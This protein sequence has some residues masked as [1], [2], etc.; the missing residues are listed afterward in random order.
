MGRHRVCT[1]MRLNG[2]RSVWRRQFVHTS[3]SKHGLAKSPNV[4]VRQFEQALPN[5]VW[6]ADVTYIRTCSGWL[7]L[8]AV[9]GLHARKIVG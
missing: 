2:L 5:R 4:L 3:D 9:L 1:L 8:A 7:Y 6:V